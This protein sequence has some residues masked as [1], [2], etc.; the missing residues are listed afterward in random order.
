MFYATSYSE[1]KSITESEKNREVSRWLNHEEDEELD[2]EL[3]EIF[4]NDEEFASKIVMSSST[5]ESEGNVEGATEGIQDFHIPEPTSDDEKE[6]N[7]P[8]KVFI[9]GASRK[10]YR[11]PGQM[12][13]KST[14]DES[15]PVKQFHLYVTS[16]ENRDRSRPLITV[17][18]FRKAVEDVIASSQMLVLQVRCG[19]L[20]TVTRQTDVD[21]I[22]KTNFPKIFGSPVQIANISK[23]DP[24]F[25]RRVFF[26]TIP[27][28]ITLREIRCC[29]ERQGIRYGRIKRVKNVVKV[30]I[31]NSNHEERL[32]KE[33]LNFYNTVSFMGI[34]EI[35]HYSDR[36]RTKE[37]IQCYNCQ[38]FWHT[39][40]NC[41]NEVR[42][43]RCGEHHEVEQCKT[44]KNNPLCCNCHG[45]HHAAYKLCPVRLQMMSYINLSYKTVPRSPNF[46]TRAS[47]S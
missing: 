36:C 4:R 21:K 16:F 1:E 41:K 11:T 13:I 30:E 20:V 25:R 32:L 19:L 22:L 26:R 5:S 45:N 44:S 18:K 3:K 43:V 15:E 23:N 47:T 8:G 35:P 31:L 34:P 24:P 29:L 17:E 38:G 2:D 12:D 33:G 37:V 9:I 40:T 39:A 42:C 27:W 14:S 46:L 6:R 10:D 7:R 28:I